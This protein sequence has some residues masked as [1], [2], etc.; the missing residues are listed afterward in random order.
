MTADKVDQIEAFMRSPA[1]VAV[2]TVQQVIA[3]A[4]ILFIKR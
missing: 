4:A 3:W 2:T 1:G